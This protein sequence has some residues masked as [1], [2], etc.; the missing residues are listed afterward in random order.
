MFEGHA[1][2]VDSL[3]T[4]DD[5]TA[6]YNAMIKAYQRLRYKKLGCSHDVQVAIM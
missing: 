2:F 4:H 6:Y 3:K 5:K 1:R